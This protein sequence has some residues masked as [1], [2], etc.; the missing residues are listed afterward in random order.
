MSPRF[1]T[2]LA[3]MWAVGVLAAAFFVGFVRLP[4]YSIGPG[5]AREVRPLITVE[6]AEVYDASGRFVMTTIEA[7]HLSAVGA[8]FAW[9]DP[10]LAVVDESTLYPPG[11]SEEEEERLAISDMD[12]SKIDATYVALEELTDYPRE[13]GSG[14][15]IRHVVPDCSADGELFP[16][17]VV[18]AIDGR[19]IEDLRDA[20]RAIETAN[21]GEALTFDVLPLGTDTPEQIRLTRAPCGGSQRPLVGISMVP[22]FP[23]DVTIRSGDVGGPSAGLM[24]AVTLYD[25][26]TP[27]DLAAG[28]TIAGT[29]TI[30]PGGEVGP[31]GGIE[32]KV[33]AAERIDAEVLL[34][35]TGDFAAARRTAPEDL[36]LVEVATFDDAI[37]YLFDSGGTARA[38][39]AA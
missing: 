17:D 38:A 31:I 37:D 15:L 29:G 9:I 3:V 19:E 27:G 8:L 24:F 28:R 14:A 22:V 26:L 13:H 6:G 35:P 2:I 7:R 33:I 23:I 25:L 34:V 10:D 36:E 5:P 20:D 32:E 39:D 16:G 12:T 21:A 30:A 1:R 18:T 4:Y 11:L